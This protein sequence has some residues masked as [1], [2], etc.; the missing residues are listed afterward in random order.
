MKT[1]KPIALLL[2]L[3]WQLSVSAQL[4]WYQNQDG[5]TPAPYGTCAV[6][7]LPFT[8]S[9]FVAAYKWSVSNDE[10][11]WKI[12]RTNYAGNELSSFY[13]TG[14]NATA[15]IK[16]DENKA[17]Y[18]LFR[19]Y[20]M[21]QHLL[22]DVYKLNTNLQPVKQRSIVIPGNFVYTAVSA[23]ELDDDGNVYFAGD[24]QFNDGGNTGFASFVWKFDRNLNSKWRRIDAGETSYT[25]LHVENNGTVRV[26]EDHYSI[27]PAIKIRKISASG[28]PQQVKT[29]QADAGRYTL[30]SLMDNS[31]NLYLYGGKVVGDTSQAMYL[32]KISR[33]TGSIAYSKT[34]H[35]ALI[36]QLSDL[37][38]DRSGNIFSL[39]NMYTSNGDELCKL[40]RINTGNGIIYWNRSYSFAN[41]SSIFTKL[42][43][44]DNSR[45]YVVGEKRS[46]LYFSKG[47]A[48]RIKKSGDD[49]TRLVSPDSVAYQ[50][51]H[52]LVNGLNDNSDRLI[53]IGNTSDFDTL[54]YSNTY[55]R[56][57]AVRF[58]EAVNGCE[59]KGGAS[60]A[61]SVGTERNSAK[62]ENNLNP[63]ITVYPNPVQ[64]QLFVSNLN[65]E[66]YDQL[67]IYNIQ[68]AKLLQQKITGDMAKTDVSHLLD[69]MYLLVLRA[70]ATMKETTIK[71]VVRK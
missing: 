57:F 69:G 26:I 18:V 50:R 12:S 8:H 13:V 3:L 70:S 29:V 45:F 56:A 17:V 58:T 10:Y 48:L 33:N 39:V 59:D 31:G 30:A 2:L 52:W 63:S 47:I 27:F 62:E 1:S 34:Y 5:N 54:T 60:A 46:Q 64:H 19:R 38:M 36:S 51:S 15:E 44:N 28:Q 24:G 40:S 4:Q 65:M 23:F 55:Q 9:S 42:V 16:V 41:D 20:D 66:G 6:S 35:T 49:E 22:L 68:G 61:E 43:V 14:S 67:S 21:E 11:T 7:V 53:A 71:F 25:G 37:K 32:Q